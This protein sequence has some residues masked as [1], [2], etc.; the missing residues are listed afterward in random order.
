MRSVVFAYLSSSVNKIPLVFATAADCA[1]SVSAR[2][3][4]NLRKHCPPG[5]GTFLCSCQPN[6]PRFARSRSPE[7]QWVL[8]LRTTQMYIQTALI[9]RLRLSQRRARQPLTYSLRPPASS[10]TMQRRGL[11]YRGCCRSSRLDEFNR[12]RRY[13]KSLPADNN[14]F[15]ATSRVLRK[16]GFS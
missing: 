15:S 16:D 8:E 1:S 12:R 9:Q 6:Y 5:F 11:I 4:V 13:R 7:P 10:L 14:E 3:C 2:I